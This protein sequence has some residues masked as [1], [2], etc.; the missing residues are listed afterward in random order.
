MFAGRRGVTVHRFRIACAAPTNGTAGMALNRMA[1]AGARRLVWAAFGKASSSGCEVCACRQCKPCFRVDMS[2]VCGAPRPFGWWPPKACAKGDAGN[3]QW[4]ALPALAEASCC[5][6]CSAIV[7]GSQVRSQHTARKYMG[8]QTL[9]S[10]GCSS[11]S[12]PG[13]SSSANANKV[14]ALHP[15]VSLCFCQARGLA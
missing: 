9:A 1:C 14:V 12:A 3:G 11:L 8:E 15:G 4:R 13:V 6:L 5:V 7:G 10:C 2:R